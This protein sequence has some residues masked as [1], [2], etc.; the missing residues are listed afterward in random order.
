MQKSKL[1]ALIAAVALIIALFAGCGSS[2]DADNSSDNSDS[3]ATTNQASD[4]S[5]SDNSDSS[6]SDAE[7]S[8]QYPLTTEDVTLSFFYQIDST[9]L[10]MTFDISDNEAY[11]YVCDL[12][13]I[14]LEYMPVPNSTFADQF[15]VLL[16]SD[17][18]PDIVSDFTVAYTNSIDQAVEEGLVIDLEEYAEYCP[19]YMSLIN[20]NAAFNADVHTDSGYLPIFWRLTDYNRIRQGLVIRQDWLDAL[21]L[22]T[23]VTYDDVHD[24]LTAFKT[25]YNANL[26]L[27]SDVST[28]FSDGYNALFTVWNTY[29]PFYQVDGVVKYGFE[30]DVFLDYLTMLNQWWNEGLIHDEGI[31]TTQHTLFSFND[32]ADYVINDEVGIF[33]T[34]AD[35]IGAFTEKS[36][37][38]DFNLVGLASPVINEGDTIKVT[39]G[40]ILSGASVNSSLPTVINGNCAYP[41]L[42][43]GFVDYFYSEEGIQMAMYGL[44]GVTCEKA[45]DGS[46]QLTE[47]VTANPDGLSTEQAAKLYGCYLMPSYAD[48]AIFDVALSDSALSCYNI[49]LSNRSTDYMLPSTVTLTADETTAFNNAIGDINTYASENVLAFVTGT[50]PLSE[51]DA[52]VAQLKEMGI[53]ECVAAYQNAYDRYIAR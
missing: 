41:E 53:D 51:F 15:N 22:D 8:T 12:T 26:H 36:D 32:D 3:S 44:E 45:A 6:G 34:Y 29:L 9:T 13:G 38:P 47:L 4:N 28:E 16:A 31:Y 18:L 14:D 43:V 20:N 49:W 42:A 52:F 48:P 33:R 2:S 35:Q 39:S 5:G 19:N 17:T 50:R 40:Y 46:L 7:V 37:D 24:V 21:G 25:E 10:G 11:Q 27:Y 1:I 23:P 30:E